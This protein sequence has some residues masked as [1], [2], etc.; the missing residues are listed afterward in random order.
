MTSYDTN[1]LLAVGLT[2]SGIIISRTGAS[3]TFA[4]T[5]SY[6]NFTGV[7]VVGLIV[8][9]SYTLAS[10]QVL[11]NNNGTM[12]GDAGLTY[13]ST[14]VSVAILKTTQRSK[15][16]NGNV[17]TPGYAFAAATNTGMYYSTALLSPII[18]MGLCNRKLLYRA[19][20]GITTASAI[21][22]ASGFTATAPHL[23]INIYYTVVAIKTASAVI[24][25]T[26]STTGIV[27]IVM[28]ALPNGPTT[29]TTSFS[30]SIQSTAG[31]GG[32]TINAVNWT[33]TN[34]SGTVTVVPSTLVS[35]ML[36]TLPAGTTTYNIYYSAE[37]LSGNITTAPVVTYL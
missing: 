11:Y 36:P 21:V 37:Q 25:A 28:N 35:A 33:I 13:A 1:G 14:T 27:R 5:S 18:S 15:A 9:N 23:A 29:V 32:S 3:V 24:T 20:V 12:Q 7:T 19:K 34:T 2:S 16:V 30:N 8:P 31:T 17:T 6:I 4:N 10:S 26:A 22:T